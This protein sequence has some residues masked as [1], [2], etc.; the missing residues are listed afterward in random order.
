MDPA[1][2]YA[3]ADEEGPL[4]RYGIKSKASAL[5]GELST[6]LSADGVLPLMSFQS[7]HPLMITIQSTTN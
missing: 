3:A 4:V 5:C 6:I 1:F 2:T 7:E